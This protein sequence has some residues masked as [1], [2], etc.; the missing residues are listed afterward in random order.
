M[1]SNIDL[2]PNASE[3]MFPVFEKI[4]VSTKTF[5][6]KT[7]IGIDLDKLYNFLPIT[8]YTIVVPKRG[9]KK[10]GDV[11][12]PN[13]DIP[14]GSIITIKSGNDVRGVVLKKPSKTKAA[15]QHRN[16]FRNSITIVIV[17][18]KQINFK[19]SKNGTFQMTG[20]KLH[21]HAEECI[22][23]I[24]DF[25]KDEPDIWSYNNDNTQLTTLYIPCMRNI[26]FSLGFT[27]DREKLNDY[28]KHHSLKII[29]KE[30]LKYESMKDV[31]DQYFHSLLE[32]LFGYTGVNIKLPL[33]NDISTMKI[34][35]KIFENNEWKE[36]M[37]TYKEYLDTL[38]E[39]DRQTK[40]SKER[41]LTFLVFHSGKIIMSGL[42]S[43]FM[44]DPYY[45]FLDIIRNAY[46]YIEE[47]LY[48][49]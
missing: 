34:K 4:K 28:M 19:I 18:D 20:C 47:R 36:E 15:K 2:K 42:T 32:T 5:T 40:L 35:K 3:L 33:T 45:F 41:Y 44:R 46:D 25:I 6:A 49:D 38:S 12:N 17:L 23:I 24:W 9:R 21:S 37:S 11:V 14:Y 39:K 30:K 43:E 26:D 8:D 48:E 13:Q 27:V 29:S 1:L 16:F 22:E 10:K 7:N 31:N